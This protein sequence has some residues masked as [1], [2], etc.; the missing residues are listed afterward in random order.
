MSKKDK[1]RRQ[2]PPVQTEMEEMD[3]QEQTI[4]SEDV[5]AEAMDDES[6]DVAQPSD[7]AAMPEDENPDGDAAVESQQSVPFMVR[8]VGKLIPKNYLVLSE[9]TLAD[10]DSE[11]EEMRNEIHRLQNEIDEKKE[12]IEGL[13]VSLKS[14]RISSGEKEKRANELQL[15]LDRANNV[16]NNLESKKEDAFTKAGDSIDFKQEGMAWIGQLLEAY[17]TTRDDYSALLK[18]RTDEKLR[19]EQKL[20]AQSAIRPLTEMLNNPTDAEKTAIKAWVNKNIEGHIRNYLSS[21]A[22]I[23]AN[24]TPKAYL[25]EIKEQYDLECRMVAELNKQLAEERS[26]KSFKEKLISGNEDVNRLINLFVSY[27]LNSLIPE[28]SRQLKTETTL[29]DTFKTI[30]ESINAPRTG[31]EAAE[32]VRKEWA[33]AVS[34]ALNCELEDV[35]SI[36]DV[37]ESYVADQLRVRVI[38]K[39]GHDLPLDELIA[40]VKTEL[41][42]ASDV[43]EAFAKENCDTAGEY[44]DKVNKALLDQ[45][46]E[47]LTVYIRGSYQEKDDELVK[48]VNTSGSIETMVKKIANVAYN[49]NLKMNAKQTSLDSIVDKTAEVAGN[50]GF[51]LNGS[52]VPEKVGCAFSR[53][54]EKIAGLKIE[55][56]T[57]NEELSTSKASHDELKG[58]VDV[59]VDEIGTTIDKPVGG[60]SESEK[61][62]LISAAVAARVEEDS[63]KEAGLQL[64]LSEEK[65]KL[66]VSFKAYLG[67]IRRAVSCIGERVGKICE[68]PDRSGFLAKAIDE[69]LLTNPAG[70]FD[71]FSHD[72]LKIIDSAETGDVESVVVK[73]RTL[74]LEYQQSTSATWMDVLM[75]IYAYSKVPF[76]SEQFFGKHI[77]PSEIAR[78]VEAL[79]ELLDVAGLKMIMPELF[80]TFGDDGDFEF[81]SI[82]NIDSYVDDVAAHVDNPD[83]IV[84]MMCVG[85]SHDGQIVKK[86]IVSVFN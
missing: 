77:I 71:D 22:I 78:A 36:N 80:V 73:I 42:F 4:N 72:L 56:E 30:A 75:R 19:M 10:R 61:L 62:E 37:V 46:V 85:I 39:I 5:A 47:N 8:I 25:Q 49:R 44:K 74:I 48:N 12:L 14:S 57:L 28:E 52:S 16:I 84:D 21:V 53:L 63:Q 58:L 79:S 66:V 35:A 33:A 43:H 32:N 64:S 9:K 27:T 3:L 40:K 34:E 55:L 59:V 11:Q 68:N 50:E 76:I 20:Q 2:T 31:E 18:E 15:K 51:E 83:R 38:D 65:E 67:T 86:P 54:S 6:E 70:G 45:L 23:P 69:K 82:R 81:E 1:K 7:S 29:E 60:K 17:L 13:E 41:A 24:K 26:L